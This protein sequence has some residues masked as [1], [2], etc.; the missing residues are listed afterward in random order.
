MHIPRLVEIVF[1]CTVQ[2]CIV[3]YCAV[4]IVLEYSIVC[5]GV[6]ESY[7]YVSCCACL[8]MCADI[9]WPPA[10]DESAR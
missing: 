3:L 10:F 9:D 5:W 8:L 7:Y 6:I 2:S 1:S 4:C